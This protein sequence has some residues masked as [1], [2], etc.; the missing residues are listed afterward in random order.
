M[1]KGL[2]FIWYMYVSCTGTR[3][4]Q[5]DDL[6]VGWAVG[7]DFQQGQTTSR[8][9]LGLFSLLLFLV[10]GSLFHRVEVCS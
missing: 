3:K 7:F 6:T 2:V 5:Y 8:L 9:S 1:G 4:T 10:P